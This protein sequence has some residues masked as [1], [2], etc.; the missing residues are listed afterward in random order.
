MTNIELTMSEARVLGD[1]SKGYSHQGFTP[2]TKR[3]LED[4]GLLIATYELTDL[5]RRTIASVMGQTA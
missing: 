5:G 4:K 2:K 3:A 1:M